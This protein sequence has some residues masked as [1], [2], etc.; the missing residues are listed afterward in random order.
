MEDNLPLGFKWFGWYSNALISARETIPIYGGDRGIQQYVFEVLD[1]MGNGM[2]CEYGTGSY[3]LYLGAPSNQSRI[4]YGG[5]FLVDETHE[6]EVDSSGEL[7]VT[8]TPTSSPTR[9][10]KPS[11][12]APTTSPT[13]ESTT[14]EFYAVPST[15]V[16]AVNDQSRPA[17]INK[18]Y[19]DYDL[20]CQESAWNKEK[21][22]ASK[23]I[24]V[25]SDATNTTT[26]DSN[27]EGGEKIEFT[28]VTGTFTCSTPGLTCTISCNRCGSIEREAADML[29]EF[30]D[31][32]TIIYTATIGTINSPNSASILTLIETDDE[33][34]NSVSCDKGCTC[35]I[36]N[37]DVLGCGF[38]PQGDSFSNS[39]ESNRTTE[40]S[41]QPVSAPVADPSD[42]VSIKAWSKVGLL[43]AC[44]ISFVFL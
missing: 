20:C 6:F 21:C 19:T 32:N 13:P 9:A 29:M 7:V 16:C 3:A 33:S 35:E 25:P 28:P 12:P 17:W 36:V 38:V 44:L 2:C 43:S 41:T 5:N 4:T 10:P 30:P 42:G 18:I 14:L 26:D 34:F 27:H 24:L 11:N 31:K 40:P 23:P 1:E 37:K 8:S 39:S 15:G 22:F